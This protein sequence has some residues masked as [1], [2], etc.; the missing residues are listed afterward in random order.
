MMQTEALYSILTRDNELKR[1]FI[2]ARV[3]YSIFF[4]FSISIK[5]IW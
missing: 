2:P 1:D 5:A 4:K 3:E